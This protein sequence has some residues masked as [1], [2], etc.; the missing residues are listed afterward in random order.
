M[1]RIVAF[2]FCVLS[3]SFVT[4]SFV[5]EEDFFDA[6]PLSPNDFF[7]EN[8][9]SASTLPWG[10]YADLAA[11]FFDNN[12]PNIFPDPVEAATSSLF[13]AFSI[14]NSD[15]DIIQS[16]S[17]S[18]STRTK[19]TGKL[20]ARDDDNSI[21]GNGEFVPSEPFKLQPNVFDTPLLLPGSTL[22][23]PSQG[24]DDDAISVESI[25][26][27]DS[28]KK[29]KEEPY[30]VNL[31]C[32]G[33]PTN[34]FSTPQIWERLELCSLCMFFSFLFSFLFALLFALLF[35]PFLLMLADLLFLCFHL[36]SSLFLSGFCAKFNPP[37]PPSFLPPKN[38]KPKT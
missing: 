36:F 8:T 6:Q 32:N 10:N 30:R 34:Y 19:T 37:L 5:Q 24:K 12:A 7:L 26:V 38:Q 11:T 9:D 3:F 14:A 15:L 23:L 33:R 17:C 35:L 13:S 2:T 29:C 21:C 27:D 28:F 1:R 4:K 20:R 18:D 31:C 25:L 22:S 16:S